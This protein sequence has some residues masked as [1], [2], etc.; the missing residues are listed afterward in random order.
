MV[1][2]L[3]CE[4]SLARTTFRD[5]DWYVA[6]LLEMKLLIRMK[7]DYTVNN[8]FARRALPEEDQAII[9]FLDKA[10]EKE[11]EYALLT[12]G[13]TPHKAMTRHHDEIRRQTRL[14]LFS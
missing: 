7:D 11:Y 9:S 14:G 1:R 6:S 3:P 2:E 13:I 10:S 8:P 12:R 5:A 4:Y